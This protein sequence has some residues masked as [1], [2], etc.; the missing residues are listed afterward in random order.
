MW[1]V[2]KSWFRDVKSNDEEGAEDPPFPPEWLCELK[3][4]QIIIFSI[5]SCD[6]AS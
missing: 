3:A 4:P 2:L 6:C 5:S 1:S